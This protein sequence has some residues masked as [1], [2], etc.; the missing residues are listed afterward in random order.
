[1]GEFHFAILIAE[2]KQ[3]LASLDQLTQECNEFYELNRAEIDTTANLRVLGS[4]LHDFYTCIEKIFRKIAISIEED[5]PSDIS[6]HSTLLDRMN[7]EI[8]SIRKPVIDEDL[9]DK[10]YDYLRFRH[11]FRNVYG[12]K[13]NWDK[14]GYLVKSI[15]N[16]QE[17]IEK[18]ITN[19]LEFLD[20]IKENQNRS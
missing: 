13:L 9:K 7:L 3:E 14:M 4:I 5:L 16:T 15:R 8:P 6:W 11:I 17:T 18:Q 1:M 10:L 12:F 19:F 2:I 20:K